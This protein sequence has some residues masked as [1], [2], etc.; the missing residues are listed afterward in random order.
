M[1]FSFFPVHPVLHRWCFF[2]SGKRR[3][4]IAWLAIIVVA[5]ATPMESAA[6][7]TLIQRHLLPHCNRVYSLLHQN[8]PEN[9]YEASELSLSNACHHL[10]GLYSNQSSMVEAEAIFLQALAE[11]KK[12]WGPNHTSTQS[13]GNDLGSLYSYV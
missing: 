8:I 11:M 9:T 1:E 12:A 10:G 6:D 4:E 2:N 5:S 13:M 7:Y 3:F